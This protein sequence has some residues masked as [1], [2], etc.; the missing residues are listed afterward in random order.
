[1]EL[2]KVE[3]E[4]AGIGVRIP[5]EIG[6]VTKDGNANCELISF[7]QEEQKKKRENSKAVPRPE[8]YGSIRYDLSLGRQQGI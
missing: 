5:R 7:R 4:V 1:M 8:E 6:Q 2:R 3:L